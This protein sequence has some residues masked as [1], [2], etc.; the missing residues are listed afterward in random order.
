MTFDDVRACL[1]RD[2]WPVEPVSERTIRSRFRGKDRV[3]HLYVHLETGDDAGGFVTFAVIPFARLPDDDAAADELGERLLRLNREMNMA[4]FSIDEDRDVVL[5]VEYKVADLDP[6][7][8]RDALD[9]LSFYADKF[10]G[11]VERLSVAR[12]P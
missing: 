1:A 6:S 4:K 3:F 8:V 9:V 7:E 10:A 11:D 5:S 2:G 12:A